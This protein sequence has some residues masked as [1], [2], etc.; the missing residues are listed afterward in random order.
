MF[1]KLKSKNA[2]IT[3]G[4]NGIGRAISKAYA[5][6]GCNVVFTYR[7][8]KHA[9]DALVNEIKS[10]GGQAYGIK[11]DLS[12]KDVLEHLVRDAISYA[13]KIDILVN[14]V[15]FL[16]RTNCFN[17]TPEQFDHVIYL[18]LKVPFF[19]MQLIATHMINLNIVGSIINISS[20]S[21]KKTISRIPHYQCAKA[22]LNMLT[23]SFATELASYQ[24]RV[25]T[26]SPGLTKTKANQDQWNYNLKVWEE[27]SKSIPLQRAG[28]PEDFQA[29]AVLLASDESQWI[30]GTN[31]T[32]D[33]GMSLL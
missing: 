6:N 31:I 22:G 20:L 18:N 13:G 10:F 30:T 23:K 15:G 25:N 3:G 27:R 4:S 5:K 2:F 26:I 9:A 28:I 12:D 33:G 17:T 16:T 21:A 32:V 1:K 14:N 24:I 8:D 19:L 11:V 7:S 29:V